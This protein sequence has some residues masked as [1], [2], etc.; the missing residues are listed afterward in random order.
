LEESPEDEDLPVA[1]LAEPV[2]VV[3]HKPILVEKPMTVHRPIP[4]EPE[5]E[6]ETATS[7]RPLFI[8]LAGLVAALVLAGAG[9]FFVWKKTPPPPDPTKPLVPDVKAVPENKPLPPVPKESVPKNQQV[10][11]DAWALRTFDTDKNGNIARDEFRNV[12]TG[13]FQYLDSNRDQILS[14]QEWRN[15]AF[16]GLDLDQNGT[17]KIQEWLRYRDWCFDTFFDANKD[18]IAVPGKEWK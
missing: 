11:V 5:P 6:A 1:S 10:L 8:G 4:V 16:S 13:Q 2:P 18:G 15:P 3:V 12:W 9:Y 7:R 17:I 14:R